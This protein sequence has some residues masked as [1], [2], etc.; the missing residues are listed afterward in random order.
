MWVGRLGAIRRGQTSQTAVALVIALSLLLS[1][2]GA[3]NADARVESQTLS[4][5]VA[6]PVLAAIVPA[7]VP[8][9]NAVLVNTI[10]VGALTP[11]II[12]PAGIAYI[13][14]LGELLVSDSEVNE[15][16]TVFTGVNLFQLTTLGAITAGGLSPDVPVEPTGLTY[17]PASQDIFI[18]NDRT[19]SVY[20]VG[21]GGDG[22]YG[23]GDDTVTS[24][25]LAPFG[26]T[27]AEDITFDTASGDLFIADGTGREIFRVDAGPNGIFEGA[28]SD[29]TITSFDISMTEVDDAEGIGYRAESDTLLIVD[30]GNNESVFEFTKD[31]YPVRR[32]DLNVI[33]MVAVPETPSD[34]VIAPA[35]DGS[36][37]DHLYIVD[38]KADNGDPE[39]EFPPA[40]DGKIYELSTAFD[41][42][43]PFVDAGVDDVVVLSVGATLDGLAYDDGQPSIGSLGVTWSMQS[44]PGTVTFANPNA[45]DTT[46]TFSVDG[47]Y[48]LELTGDDTVLTTSDTVQIV[49]IPD[50]ILNTAPVPNAGSDESVQLANGAVLGGSATDD[51]LPNPPAAMTYSWTKFA[52]PGSV[53]FGAPTSLATSVTFST[54]GDYTLR[55]TANDSELKGT[56]DVVITVTADPIV[57][58]T[59]ADTDAPFVD[60]GGLSAETVDAIDC[61]VSY[62]VAN[63]TSP[64]TFAPLN[65]VTRWQ[66]ALF[67]TREAQVL[68]VTLPDGSDQGFTDI[69]GYQDSTQVA[70]NQL[71]QLGITTG[72]GPD[73]Y[74][75]AE[76]VPRWQMA[77]FL[78]RLLVDTG[79]AL[80]SGADQGYTD[81]GAYAGATQTAINQVTQL[82]IAQGTGPGVFDPASPVTRWQM[83]LFLNRTLTASGL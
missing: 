34:V 61:L 57:V 46:A 42:V 36:G 59:C 26:A 37:A 8:V 3:L 60:L 58:L 32:I 63:G 49:V 5:A 9:E 22:V 39:D 50:P 52:G 24:F 72:T 64:T 82:S 33:N 38:R 14:H 79:I 44:G 20:R 55:L 45:Q 74:G 68:G 11:A 35:S 47:T 23:T 6:R 53:T 69:A 4:V 56:D 40:S 48:I 65:N 1:G 10:D 43:A 17:D 70:I 21:A 71:A 80:P 31:G 66:M 81:I 67:L 15:E 18:S 28:D 27:D 29:D 73:T 13:E 51:G 2:F 54:V 83:A 30:A 75:P 7:T 19:D 16:P 12:D 62:G 77:L 25:S 78:T 76:V 41:N